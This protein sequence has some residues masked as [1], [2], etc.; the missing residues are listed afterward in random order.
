MAFADDAY[1]AG[2][3]ELAPVS[4]RA[5][6]SLSRPE[7]VGYLVWGAVAA[8]IAVPEI[9]ALSGSPRWPTISLTAA[10]LEALWS[11]TKAVIVALISAAV[12]QL[13]TYSGPRPG[14][15]TARLPMGRFTRAQAADAEEA[16][17]IPF[18]A[19]YLP[20][21]AVVTAAASA[22]TASVTTDK[23]V[24]GYVLYGT[25]ALMLVIIPDTAAY[26]FAREVPFPTLF[27][28]LEYLDARYHPALLVVCSGLTVL[29]IHI[30]AYPWP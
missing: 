1:E 9:W 23:F 10:H 20:L 12:V 16:R 30:V 17:E 24:L 4:T 21:A 26:V 11:P 15:G 13:M 14:G 28:T 27:R 6:R 5:V 25:M 7:A 29:A 2:A 3:P 18:A 8:I 19:W 22:I